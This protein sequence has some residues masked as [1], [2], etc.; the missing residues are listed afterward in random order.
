MSHLHLILPLLSRCHIRDQA[1]CE[2]RRRHCS[3]HNTGRSPI[4][5]CGVEMG[6]RVQQGRGA[7]GRQ[8]RRGA[9]M[10]A[11]PPAHK[12]RPGS[13]QQRDTRHQVPGTKLLGRRVGKL[14][15]LQRTG[16]ALQTRGNAFSDSSPCTISDQ[17]TDSHGHFRMQGQRR[18]EN[19]LRREAHAWEMA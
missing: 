6:L 2:T 1:Q 3:Q 15:S 9:P 5:Q 14:Q 18:A 17:G 16:W 7:T 4:T 12:Q 10:V 13:V 11:P 8:R 19:E